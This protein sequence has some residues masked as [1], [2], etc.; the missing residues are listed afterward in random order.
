M[1]VVPGYFKNNTV[2]PKDAISVPD[3]TQVVISVPE[4]AI[5][6]EITETERQRKIF[7][8]FFAA[9]KQDPQKLTETFDKT[10]EAGIQLREYDWS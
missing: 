5:R 3:G 1:L 2:V 8:E 10:I 9:L 7:A 4:D 6:T